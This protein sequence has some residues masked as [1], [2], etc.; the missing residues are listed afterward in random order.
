MGI[1]LY[2]TC[3]QHDG[4]RELRLVIRAAIHHS[5]VN[6]LIWSGVV[7][8]VVE[9]RVNAMKC[10]S[11]LLLSCVVGLWTLPAI[12]QP[13]SQSP[14]SA[15]PGLMRELIQCLE[16]RSAD[17]RLACFD[18]EATIVRRGQES[19]GFVV[20]GARAAASQRDFFGLDGPPVHIA[21][22]ADGRG[23]LNEVTTAIASFAVNRSGNVRFSTQEGAVWIQTDNIPVLGR[24]KEGDSV[25]IERAALGSYKAKVGR[26]RAFRV[27]RIR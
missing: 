1:P 8:R 12:A 7:Q 24:V 11:R 2:V 23:E 9:V 18:R 5:C 6:Q 16:I 22:D 15:A 21:R 25:T 19:Q 13:E 10:T 17:D 14:S 27:E 4:S 3:L 20:D 26:R